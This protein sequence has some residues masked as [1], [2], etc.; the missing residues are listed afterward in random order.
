LQGIH[1][2][3]I[4]QIKTN[5]NMEVIGTIKH[6]GETETVSDRF[7]KREIV[8][9]IDPDSTYPQHVSFQLT[10]DKCD[11]VNSMI[12]GVQVKAQFNLR[13]RE[14][15]GPQGVKY[16]NTLEIWRMAVVN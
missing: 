5:I 3:V 1:S 2:H 14:W 11:L 10:Q 15:N 16:F 9:T 8:I 4:N 12:E 13:G 6:I 7:K